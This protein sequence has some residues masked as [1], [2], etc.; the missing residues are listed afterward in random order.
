MQHT[1]ELSLSRVLCSEVTSYRMTLLSPFHSAHLPV[2][3]LPPPLLPPTR[4]VQSAVSVLTSTV[5]AGC[6][7][8]PHLPAMHPSNACPG[9]EITTEETWISDL[10]MKDL[11]SFLHHIV[12]KYPQHS[13]LV[14]SHRELL[15]NNAQHSTHRLAAGSPSCV[16]S[17]QILY[18]FCTEYLVH[19]FLQCQTLFF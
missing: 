15:R 10:S 1:A 16:V 12:N 2:S 13:V 17:M 19:S 6:S 8:R 3:H 5:N 4:C 14:T 11:S 7:D 9:C 18:F